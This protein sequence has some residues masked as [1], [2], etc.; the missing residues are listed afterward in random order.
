MLNRTLLLVLLLCWWCLQLISTTVLYCTAGAGLAADGTDILSEIRELPAEQQAAAVAIVEQEEMAALQKLELQ[1][2]LHDLMQTLRV[3]RVRCAIATRN[4]AAAVEYFLSASGLHAEAE[5]FTP[6]LTRDFPHNK[7]DARV[8]HAI[9]QGARKQSSF[10]SRP[11][12]NCVQN[13]SWCAETSS[14]T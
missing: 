1:P 8:A 2:G 7:P 4:M 6:V 5:L 3:K 14:L 10:R 13:R 12:I 11:G 9:A